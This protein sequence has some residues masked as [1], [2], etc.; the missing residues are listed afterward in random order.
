MQ[1]RKGCRTIV[2]GLKD[3]VQSFPAGEEVDT[4][5]A[6]AAAI[7]LAEWFHGREV[8]VCTHVDWDHIHTH[9]IVNSVSLEDGK[10]LH[11]AKSELGS[12]R[13]WNDQCMRYAESRE[14]FIT[15]MKSEGYDVCWAKHQPIF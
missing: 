15:L 1:K 5:K 9:L 8:L 11:I 6:H 7:K 3:S 10:K 13:Y 14:Q 12:L 2:R 4:K